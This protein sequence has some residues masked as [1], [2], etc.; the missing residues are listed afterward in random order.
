MA[1]IETGALIIYAH[2]RPAAGGIAPSN[3]QRRFITE[4]AFLRM[5][6]VWERFLEQSFVRYLL[7]DPSTTGGHVVR[8]MTPVDEAHAHRVVVGTLKFFDWSLPDRIRTMAGHFFKDGEPFETVLKGIHSELMDLKTMRNAAAH[9]STST[10]SQLDA[11]GTRLL[12]QPVN[13]ID[14]YDLILATDPKAS[15]ITILQGFL[16]TLDAAAEAIARG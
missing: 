1:V 9:L 11:L 16:D 10:S 3:A 6:I 8:Y 15:R 14:V 12:R 7:G 4:A 5:F 13:Q 2:A